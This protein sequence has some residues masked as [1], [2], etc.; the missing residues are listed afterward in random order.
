MRYLSKYCHNCCGE[1]GEP[2]G[3]PLEFD[4]R[5]LKKICPPAKRPLFQVRQWSDDEQSEQNKYNPFPNLFRR[6]RPSSAI[7]I[8][9]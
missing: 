1:S 2:Y 5:I 8:Q 7:R 9:K 6:E 4:V 3:H